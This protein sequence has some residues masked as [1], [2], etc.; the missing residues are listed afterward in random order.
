VAIVGRPNVG[1]ST[2]FNRITNDRMAITED[3]PGTT[4]DRL[5]ADC[6]WNDSRFLLVDTAGIDYEEGDELAQSVLAQV[7]L[8]I[9]QADVLIF[10]VDGI[11][12]LT[13]VDFDVAEQLRR[14]AKPVLLAV[15]K[16]D[17]EKRSGEATQV[18]ELGLGEPHLISAYHNLGVFDMLNSL[19]EMLPYAPPA[20]EDEESGIID[21][22]IV[23]RPNVGKSQLVNTLL[24]ENR[25][26]VSNIAGT[27]RDAID[28]L[29][30]TNGKTYR[31]IDTAG[32]R[33]RGSIARG[34]E[35]FSV[36][37]SLRAINR[38]DVVLL[39]LDATEPATAQDLH[40]AG[41]AKEAYKGIVVLV[42]KWDL[43]EREEDTA[44]NF[45]KMLQARFRFMPEVP[46]LFVSALT[47]F[48]VNRIWEHV[49][50]IAAGRQMRISTADVNRI[51]QKAARSS[52]L[53]RDKGRQ[54]NVLYG[55]QTAVNPPTFQIFVNDPALVH[56]SYRRYLENSLREAFGFGATPLKLTFRKREPNG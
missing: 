38:A 5:Y 43:I 40:V 24:G 37:R 21:V 17:S 8:A 27:T 50:S 6:T 29:L 7:N 42:N 18:Y 36:L 35:K 32:I 55:T 47:G 31:L 52:V 11:A 28:T 51:L 2:L 1:K 53:P 12:E 34:I 44:E 23:G 46:I 22:A 19:I 41:Y 56:F 20:A 25:M 39:L 13:P 3:Q 4:R 26:V 9:D 30:E 14:S 45:R 54:L 15:N 33:K 49:D 48:H 10:V 16:I